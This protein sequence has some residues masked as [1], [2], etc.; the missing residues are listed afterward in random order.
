MTL[1]DLGNLGEF[2][3]AIGVVASLIYLALQIRQN[4]RQISQNTNA[5]KVASADS[6]LQYGASM[7]G[8][9]I[10]DPAVARIWIGGMRDFESLD[11]ED[12]VR[13]RFIMLN[14]FYGCQNTFLHAREGV[15]ESEFWEADESALRFFMKEP[16]VRA[17]WR[18]EQ[19]YL[20]ATFVDHVNSLLEEALRSE[21]EGS[22]DREPAA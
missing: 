14:F 16:G 10:R 22:A 17:W 4:S 19:A 3:G 20:V 7:R 1:Q 6:Y 21:P 15:A 5:V 9:I 18:H 11:L 12:R 2:V 13:F 8:E